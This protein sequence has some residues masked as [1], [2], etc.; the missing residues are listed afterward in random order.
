[1]QDVV[2]LTH[3]VFLTWAFQQHD[4]AVTCLLGQILWIY[5]K[6]H[7]FRLKPAFKTVGNKDP[8]GIK[9]KEK[10]KKGKKL[11]LDCRDVLAWN[12]RSAVLQPRLKWTVKGASIE[13]LHT[14]NSTKITST[15]RS[16]LHNCK[17]CTALHCTAKISR[18]TE[19]NAGWGSESCMTASSERDWLET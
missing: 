7:A 17:D 13:K 4:F 6:L 14:Q 3:V 16:F 12:Y 5:G 15:W 8:G 18:R 19:K 9:K 1:M 2:V 10:R 11:Q